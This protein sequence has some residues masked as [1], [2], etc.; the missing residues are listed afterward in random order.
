MPA[1]VSRPSSTRNR[2][3]V[4]DSG[5]GGLS[6]LREIQRLLPSVPTLYFADQGHLPYGPRP[7]EEIRSFVEGIA[8]FLIEQ[9]ADVIVLACHAASAAGLHELRAQYPNA[10][11][12]GIE[13]AVKPA[14]E[15]T[16]TGVIGVLTTQATADGEL[17]RRVCE[18]FAAHVNV[19]TRVSPDLVALVEADNVH[20]P[21]GRQTIREHVQPLLDA[22]A[23][24]LVLACTHF[25]FLADALRAITDVPLV[26][27]A[28]AVARQVSRVIPNA[29]DIT[30]G[31]GLRPAPTSGE[32]NRYFT[33]GDPA[34]FQLMLQRLIGV[35]EALVE[36][37]RWKG[38]RIV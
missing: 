3:G 19:I 31:A 22:G 34:Q 10:P 16:Q 5:V 8:D 33:S 20:M 15:A 27:P 35:D 29:S 37:V 23:D 18:R 4:F 13:P 2:I 6:V 38:G 26:D 28:P 7:A 32:Q 9:G 14:A 25:P 30:V 36:G 1:P 17:Y 11:F 21:A 24:Q 12:V